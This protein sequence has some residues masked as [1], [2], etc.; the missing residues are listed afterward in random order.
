MDD[1]NF[2]AF[3]ESHCD[4]CGSD[5]NDTLFVK[6]GF[7]HVRCRV[8]GMVFVN[9][10]L[11][12]HT[13]HQKSAGTGC[14]GED[15]L[16]RT[17]TKR[18]KKEVAQLK[19]YRKLNRILDIGA[20]RGWFLSEAKKSGWEVWATE[21][22][23]D[24]LAHLR[25]RGF[26]KVIDQSGEELGVPPGAFDVV[27]LWDVIE[28][29]ESPS[30]GLANIAE[31]LRPGGLLRLSTTN[32]ASLSYRV[33]GP[34]W[35]YINGSDHIHLFEPATIT[36]LLEMHRFE[37]VRIRTRSFNLRRKLYHPPRELPVGLHPLR[38][39]R[40]LIDEAIRFTRYGHQLVVSARKKDGTR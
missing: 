26:Q 18:L 23:S 27:R 10:R 15:D 16:S 34:E 14:M 38:P 37:D 5:Q 29:M 19:R 32:L 35:V 36:R 28:H 20:G 25:S 3:I 12:D 40:K 4:V 1:I 30:R 33:N 8:C 2:A 13:E 21:V 6:E 17:Q 7:C 9:P 31:A 11:R 39:L 22:N 24:A